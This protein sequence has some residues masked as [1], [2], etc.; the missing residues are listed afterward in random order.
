[1]ACELP[2]LWFPEKLDCW[3]LRPCAFLLGRL[4]SQWLCYGD[5]VSLEDFQFCQMAYVV[6]VV[7]VIVVPVNGSWCVSW[8]TGC[9]APGPDKGLTALFWLIVP[10]PVPRKLLVFVEGADNTSLSP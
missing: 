4:S 6:V 7:V 8:L 5:A 9:P 1:M 10:L 3:A 2:G